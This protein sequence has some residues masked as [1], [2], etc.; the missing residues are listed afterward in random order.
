MTKH[1]LALARVLVN[2]PQGIFIFIIYF[3]VYA[4]LFNP[5]STDIILYKGTH[6]AVFV[7]VLNIGNS[8]E[9]E[10]ENEDVCEI[11]EHR[12]SSNEMFP[13]YME[14]MYQSGIQ[15][16]SI[17]EA[18]EFK[19][20]LLQNCCVFADPDG[21]T[22]HTLLGKHEIKLKKEIPIKDPP[23]RVPPWSAPIVLVQ[24][25]DSSWRLCVDYRKLNDRTIKDAYPIP[26]IEDNL[27]ALNGSKW[28]SS[29]DLDMAYHQIPMKLCDKEKTAFATPMGGLYQYTA[30][31]FGLC[32][33]ASTF[34]RIIESALH[35]LQWHIEVLYLDDIIVIGKTFN[36]I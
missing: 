7:P 2:A 17:K 20:V 27:D 16:L 1:G 34:Q 31:P 33:A 26:R 4:R 9:V 35:G 32:N 14:K 12:N 24:K 8:V 3:M 10:D 13:Q 23:R 19:R 30:M 21:Q 11:V 25:K 18:D 15:N 36:H 5:T 6:I 28:F 29:L 22:G